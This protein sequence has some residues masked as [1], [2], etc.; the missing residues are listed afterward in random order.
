MSDIYLAHHGILGQ[1]WGVRR[2]QNKD[3]SY[4]SGSEGRY[5]KK[6]ARAGGSITKSGKYKASNGVVIAKSK[7]KSVAA[8][9]KFS[10]TLAGQAIAATA[11]KKMA[12]LTGRSVDSIKQQRKDERKALK[13][14]YKAGGD[15][16]I[17]K[18]AST[19]YSSIK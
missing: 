4:K 14:Y 10:T 9:R 11:D 8:M 3:G 13:E 15:R 17:K 2:F 5:A 18:Y 1:K 19:A 12:K 16:M 7:N 6:V